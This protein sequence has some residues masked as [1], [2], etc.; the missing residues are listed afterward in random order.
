MRLNV[1]CVLLLTALLV[2]GCGKSTEESLANPDAKTGAA[3]SEKVSL[4]LNWV[5][6]AEHGGF[7]AADV[8]GY[9]DVAGLDVEIKPG[10]K[11]SP[12]LQ[13]V[14]RK[15]V[16]FGVS[17]ADKIVSAWANGAKVVAIMAPIQDSPRC[18]IVHAES[19]ITEFEQLQNMTLSMKGADPWAKFMI[20]RL[21]LQSKDIT[22]TPP[23]LQQ[24]MADKKSG[25][26][27]YSFSE[28]FTAKEQ[29]AEPVE[30]MVSKL[31]F[32]PY[33]SVLITH[34]DTIKERPDLVRKMVRASVWGWR[35]YLKSPEKTNAKIDSLNEHM[36]P[37]ALEFGANSL[38]PLCLTNGDDASVGAMTA[39]RWQAL[40]DQMVEVGAIEADSVTVA[41]VFTDKFL[42]E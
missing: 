41:E 1:Q 9:F 14:A 13:M 34:P 17:N 7:Y 12:V 42:K 35:T 8:H 4:L 27:A 32:N 38:K 6:E 16:S 10:G 19:G 5:P 31:G 37:A 23:S 18:I 33:T 25:V 24:F 29:G 40:V 15:E 22:I 3:G 21:D 2:I 28:P 20:K 30:L 11:A 36:T 39:D 26:Q